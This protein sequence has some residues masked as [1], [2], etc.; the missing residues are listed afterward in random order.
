MKKLIILILLCPVILRAQNICVAADCKDTVFYPQTTVTLTGL[1]TS[2]DPVKSYLWKNASGN[3]VIANPIITATS[4]SGLTVSGLYIFTFTATTA[5]ATGT[6]FDTVVYV[7]AKPPVVIVGPTV[8]TS[9][10][11]AVLSG[12]NSYDP[13][14]QSVTYSWKQMGGPNTATINVPTM[15]NPLLSGLVN[16]VYL[17]QLI[18]TN[19][20]KLSAVATQN[21][22]VNIPV[23]KPYIL[24]SST[25][26]T[27]FY[28]DSTRKVITNNFP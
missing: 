11:T 13:N 8:N 17:F 14:G 5:K 3:A 4:A 25:V 10:N 6:A 2:T 24:R 1:A 7:A 12:S 22:V 20:A 16:G 28:S 19:T 15:S 27:F 18:T 21:V 9:I 26:Q 23:T